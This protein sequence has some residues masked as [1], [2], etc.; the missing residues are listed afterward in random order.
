MCDDTD[1]IPIMLLTWVTYC[2]QPTPLESVCDLITNN[3]NA[4]DANKQAAI[5]NLATS[6]TGIMG[7]AGIL[8]DNEQLTLCSYALNHITVLL[9][10]GSMN[11]TF[12][13][14]NEAS[15]VGLIYFL[16]TQQIEE[17]PEAIIIGTQAANSLFLLNTLK[18]VINDAAEKNTL[19][20]SGTKTLLTGII[21]F[22]LFAII[23]NI[24]FSN[25]IYQDVLK[26]ILIST[27]GT[28]VGAG[29]LMQEISNL[30]NKS[31]QN[32]TEDRDNRF[33]KSYFKNYHSIPIQEV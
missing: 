2:I 19:I 9:S 28:V 15:S 6:L 21:L 7:V 14:L 8:S 29:S 27:A 3:S 30:V 20:Q 13:L 22:S 24:N 33:K 25:K 16:S 17:L 11:D 1:I 26:D 32:I 31:I 12:T 23:S 4:I 18:N 10:S 5:L